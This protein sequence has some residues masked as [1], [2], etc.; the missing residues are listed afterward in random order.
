LALVAPQYLNDAQRSRRQEFIDQMSGSFRSGKVVL[1]EGGWQ[2]EKTS[3]S[4][5]DAELLQ[6][7]MF[8]VSEI[9]RAFNV[10]EVLLQMGNRSVTDM[11]PAISQLAQLCL[12]PICELI[13]DEFSYS[14]LPDGLRLSLDTDA[15]SDGSF[16][17]SLRLLL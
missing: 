16:N 1:I 13:Q 17:L 7:R 12:R 8:S 14:L 9:C 11:A 10:P 2:I 5:V 4:S 6:S 3:F 15:L